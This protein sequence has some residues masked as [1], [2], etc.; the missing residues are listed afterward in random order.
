MGELRR[1]QN[2]ASHEDF[3]E[4]NNRSDNH[5]RSNNHYDKLS[6]CN[7]FAQN[8]CEPT[9]QLRAICHI[10]EIARENAHD[11]CCHRDTKSTDLVFCTD[12]FCDDQKDGKTSCRP[13]TNSLRQH[14][15]KISADFLMTQHNFESGHKRELSPADETKWL[16]PRLPAGLLPSTLSQCNKCDNLDSNIAFSNITMEDMERKP[17]CDTS[18][19]QDNSDISQLR[20]VGM[21][22]NKENEMK[23]TCYPATGGNNY[24][25][26]A[27]CVLIDRRRE[28]KLRRVGY[29]ATQ[30]NSH[31]LQTTTLTQLRRA[32]QLT[33]R[34]IK[35]TL[36]Y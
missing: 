35:V 11:K 19:L 27:R 3:R 22:S 28:K 16:S 2:A 34:A 10:N 36:V 7:T 21:S 13:S 30:R 4:T 24:S 14:V 26:A 6:N 9:R 12:Q 20:A 15:K 33:Q 5:F 18:L 32:R 17:S 8:I 23:T 25:C 29:S 1:T 31:A